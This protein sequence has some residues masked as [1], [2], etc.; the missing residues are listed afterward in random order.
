MSQKNPPPK[1][2]KNLS[3]EMKA[4]AGPKFQNYVYMEWFE[5]AQICIYMLEN[6]LESFCISLFYGIFWF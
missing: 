2:H 5:D 1:P 3:S 4:P 6:L